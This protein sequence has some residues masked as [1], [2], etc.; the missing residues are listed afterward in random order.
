MH[1]DVTFDNI[2]ITK[3]KE[4]VFYDFDSGGP[5]WRAIDLQGWA[6][7]DPIDNPKQQ[8]FVRGYRTIREINVIDIQAAPYLHAATEFWGF[9]LDL[10]RRVSNQGEQTIKDYLITKE[11]EIRVFMDYLL[12]TLF[13]R[14]TFACKSCYNAFI[15]VVSDKS[16]VGKARSK[17]KTS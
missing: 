10:A 5:G 8:D 2:H 15:T 1:A 9:A 6:V 11:T 7:F 17:E 13:E 4:V 3:D 16:S 12:V 14:K